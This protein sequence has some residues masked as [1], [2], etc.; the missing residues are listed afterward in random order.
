[1][2]E[3]EQVAAGAVRK[4]FLLIICLVLT[5]CSANK[6]DERDAGNPV[7]DYGLLLTLPDEP[8]S[9]ADE[10][11]PI[12]ENRCIVC[13]GCYDAPCQLKLSSYEGIVRGANPEK[14]YNGRPLRGHATL[15]TRDRREND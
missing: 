1:M 5:A 11:Q 8:I 9:F 15:A 14:V 13:H 2:I 3:T 4:L 10:V 7:V 6:G 12:L